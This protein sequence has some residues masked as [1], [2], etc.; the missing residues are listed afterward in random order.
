MKPATRHPLRVLSVTTVRNEGPYLVEWIAHHRA[1]GVT[2]FLICSN[3]CD[4][5]THDLLQALDQA[6]IITHV[7]H[8]PGRNR[9]IQWQALRLAW[10]HDLRKAADWILVSDVD[11][12]LNIH[13]DGH[14]IPALLARVPETTDAIVLP[15]RLFGHNGVVDIRD[16]PVTEQF[17]RAAPPDM[18]FPI[19]AGLFKTLF[20]AR[21]PFNQLGVHRPRQKDP[22]K[23]EL[24]HFVD[25]SGRPMHPIL[26][27]A[28]QRLALY[29]LGVARDLV[30]L[31]HYAVRSAAG[32]VLKCDR[33]LPNRTR[34]PV[35]LAYWTERNFNA[36][37]DTSIA[38]M[39]PATQAQERRLRAL[40]EV[41]A[42][43]AQA[44]AWHQSRFNELVRQPGYQTLMTQILV[45]GGSAVLP[46]RLQRQLVRWYQEANKNPG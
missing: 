14:D 33:G 41:A 35:D 43:H 22:E 5:G 38:R 37:T 30:E 13:A 1:A 4:D 27:R 34:K 31:N 16:A 10:R 26:A 20:R 15:W 9:S 32:F 42:L 2:D 7:P 36:V 40:P 17:T 29:D 8:E 24:P 44:V 45:A 6:G 28:P 19:A 46:Q 21:G 18:Q 23:A 25:G 39:R 3:D 12:F 11:E